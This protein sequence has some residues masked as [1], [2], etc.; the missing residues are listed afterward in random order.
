MDRLSVRLSYVSQQERLTR[1]SAS[2]EA[3]NFSRAGLDSLVA[4]ADDILL[5]Q[6]KCVDVETEKTVFPEQAFLR[7]VRIDNGADAVYIMRKKSMDMRVEISL[8]REI[9]GDRKF[10]KADAE[11]RV[12]I[13]VGDTGMTRGIT[14]TAVESLKFR[15]ENSGVFLPR[16]RGV[17]E[18]DNDVKKHLLPEFVSPIRPTE[19]Q[20]PPFAVVV[21]LVA[22]IVPF[23]LVYYAWQNMG[24]LPVV[25]P[26]QKSE[27]LFVFGFESC[28][29]LIMGALSMFWWKWNIIQMWKAVVVLMVPT[30]IC[31]HRVLSA[32]AERYVRKKSKK[33]KHE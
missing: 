10:W 28:I 26:E 3:P 2:A 9:R 24:V 11:Y 19:K 15:K 1:E 6:A 29:L 16:A 18:F 7:F 8:R 23:P 21:A 22:L 20:A 31:G 4:D 5:A 30:I 13:I 14:W 12:E 25:L 17:F 27:R 32:S 33:S